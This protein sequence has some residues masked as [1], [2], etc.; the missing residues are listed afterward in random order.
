M[1]PNSKKQTISATDLQRK[2]GDITRLVTQ[3][4]M[5]L[6]VHRDSIP[7]MMI[8]PI[9]AYDQLIKDQ[10]RLEDIL[11]RIAKTELREWR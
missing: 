8:L 4:G 2:V 5:H 11:Q 10:E 6:T 1:I 3:E 9:S 7:I